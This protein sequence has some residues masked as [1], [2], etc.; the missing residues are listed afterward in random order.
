M[1]SIRG[2]LSVVCAAV[3]LAACGTDTDTRA[4]PQPAATAASHESPTT[5]PSMPSEATTAPAVTVDNDIRVSIVKRKVT[6]PTGRVEV[7]KGAL[8]RITVTSDA[9]DN[10][11][12]HGYD[13]EVD[14]PAG[15]PASVQFRANQSG[16]FEVET[17]NTHLV[18]LQLM[19]R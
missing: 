10:L 14:L 19:V 13:L 12:L 4:A 17:H 9:A 3:L 6:P 5:L 18:L 7:R 2:S 15:Q 8:V 11:H 1:P 16:L